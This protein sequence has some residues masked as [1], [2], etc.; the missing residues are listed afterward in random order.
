LGFTRWWG[1][2]LSYLTTKRHWIVGVADIKQVKLLWKKVHSS[3][4][5]LTNPNHHDN[6]TV[7]TNVI[8]TITIM[9]W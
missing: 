8:R 2:L 6:E 1:S 4:K 7:T 3:V 9:V 5:L